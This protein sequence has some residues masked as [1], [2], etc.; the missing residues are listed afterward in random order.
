MEVRNTEKE[1]NS[2]MELYNDLAGQKHSQ[3]S[4][5]NWHELVSLQEN[6]KIEKEGVHETED[7]KEISAEEF[8][9]QLTAFETHVQNLLPLMTKFRQRL[10]MKDP[11]TNAPRYG[12]KTAKRVSSLLA[13]YDI[14]TLAMDNVNG[15]DGEVASQSSFIQ[16]LKEKV[17]SEKNAALEQE[18]QKEDASRQQKIAQQKTFL[19][20]EEKRK[21]QKLEEGIRLQKEREELAARAE[22]ARIARIE[23]ERRLAQEE[24]DAERAYLDSISKNVDGVK[25]QLGILRQSCKST[26]EIDTAL[27]ALHT[28]FHQISARPEEVKFRRIRRDHPKFLEDIG[29]HK[30]GQEVLIA[31]GFTFEEID[32]LK[33]L[34][35][36]EPDVSELDEWSDW[37]DLIKGTLSAIEEEMIK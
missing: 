30:G 27:G 36:K 3:L 15:R 32:G 16:I 23:N 6:K 29:R 28:L 5:L 12:E 10:G 21:Q 8:L 11:V 24:R 9:A 14:L 37:F 31:A 13:T 7:K 18:K 26:A 22:I 19:L 34:F 2:I 33:C 20:E 17:Q 25:Q 35:S 4:V 1:V